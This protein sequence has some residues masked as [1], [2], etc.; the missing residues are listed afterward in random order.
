MRRRTLL[1]AALACLAL[2]SSSVPVSHAT[3]RVDHVQVPFYARDIV[4]DKWTAWIFYRPQQCI[5]AGF[6]LL[7][8]FDPP[9]VFGCGP[10]TMDGYAIFENGP[11]IDP[12]PLLSRLDGQ[13]AVPLW[14][15]RTRAFEK[16]TADGAITLAELAALAPLRGTARLYS[17][18]LRTETGVPGHGFSALAHGRLADGR[19]FTYLTVRTIAHGLLLAELKIH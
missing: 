9:R 2:W 3:V 4:G 1:G 7:T 15:V 6:N 14:F 13:G 10:M 18:V 16:A 19:S 12:A 11:G 17:E 5:P 8:F